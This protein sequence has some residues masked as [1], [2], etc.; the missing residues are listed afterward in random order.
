MKKIEAIIQ[1]P[2]LNEVQYALADIGIE[3]MTVCEVKDYGRQNRHKETYR[4]TEYT[5]NHLPMIKIDLV[6]PDQT[7]EQ[8]VKIIIRSAKTAGSRGDGKVLI[9][10]VSEAQCVVSI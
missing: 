10:D 5:V 4:S 9:S 6:V 8:A 7:L 3:E 2:K 1:Q